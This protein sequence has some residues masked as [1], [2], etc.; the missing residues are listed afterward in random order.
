MS[1]INEMLRDLDRRQALAV[2]EGQLPPGQVTAVGAPP[3]GR[4]WFWTIVA[5]L[6]VVAL[7]WVGWVAYQIHARPM[8]ATDL[9]FKAAEERK[10]RPPEPQAAP[11]PAKETEPPELFRLAQLI[12]TPI[13]ET[14][15]PI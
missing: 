9:A 13:A 4:Q 10:A 6:M 11:E 3:P 7:A 15:K 2:A 12:E 8:L 1:L 14:V 5:F